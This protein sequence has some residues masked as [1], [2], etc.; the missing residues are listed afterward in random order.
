MQMHDLRK[1]STKTFGRTLAFASLL[2][3]AAGVSS[4]QQPS[5]G[6]ANI[7]VGPQYDSTHVHGELLICLQFG[8]F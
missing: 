2:L 5:A 1:F 6:D 4:G 3:L 7:A 8:E